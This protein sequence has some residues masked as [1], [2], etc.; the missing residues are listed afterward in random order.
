[1]N[2]WQKLMCF[3]GFHDLEKFDP[4]WARDFPPELRGMHWNYVCR[5]CGKGL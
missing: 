1:M 3:F 2:K 4:M 5:R